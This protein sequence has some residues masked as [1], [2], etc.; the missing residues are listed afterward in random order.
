MRCSAYNPN[1]LFC[2]SRLF[3]ASRQRDKHASKIP[4]EILSD[5]LSLSS[6]PAYVLPCS[7]ARIVYGFVRLLSPNYGLSSAKLL[8]ES[9]VVRSPPL[10]HFKWRGSWLSTYLGVP[11]ECLSQVPCKDLFS[12]SLHRPF[13]CAHTSLL[14]YTRNIPDANVI[15]RLC[16]LSTADFAK[17]WADRPFILTDP[18]R[19]WP[20]YQQWSLKFLYKKYTDT[21]FRAEA[22]DWPYNVYSDYM[23]ANGD[24]SPLYLFDRSFVE[25]MGLKV[26]DPGH[27]DYWSPECFGEDLFDVLEDQRPDRRWL[28]V[29]PA[30]SGSTFH[31]DPN[32]TR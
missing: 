24:E 1:A 11:K 7:S 32:A 4:R 12:D 9:S 3:Q 2:A 18:I 8:A 28:I 17:N 19:R 15:P 10:F 26:G 25:K 14:P 6:R 21:A 23:F 22:V 20:A 5:L 31:K 13:L 27:S 29:G 30:R 16:N